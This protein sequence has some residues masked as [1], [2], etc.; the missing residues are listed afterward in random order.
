[1][2]N[3]VKVSVEQRET[4]G[5]QLSKLRAKGLIPANISGGGKPSIAVQLD[6]QTFLSITKQRGAPVLRISVEPNGGTD[7]ALLARV[8]RNPISKAILHVDFRRIVMSKPIKARVPLHTEGDAPAVKVYNGVL[9][10]LMENV[11]VEA[12][13]ANLPDA[14]TID[15][16]GLLELNAILT[17][18]DIK[19]PANV[20]V[21]VAPDEPVIMIKAPRIEAATE[22][23]E[24]APAAAA[25]ATTPS[26]ETGAAESRAG[27]CA[28]FRFVGARWRASLVGAPLSAARHRH[29]ADA[30]LG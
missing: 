22:A 5:K 9:L 29:G 15:I 1:V 19:T 11:E 27:C 24:A 4:I 13:P 23:A 14:L 20:T 2:A 10:H 25:S 30:R 26:G 28:S 16:S 18:K 8:E 12:L 21:L 17:A 7:M 6:Q 3:E